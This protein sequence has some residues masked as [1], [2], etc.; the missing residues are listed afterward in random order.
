MKEAS[1]LKAAAQFGTGDI[2]QSALGDGLIH[3]TYNVLYV[4]SGRR[5]VLQCINQKTFPQPENIIRN[6]CMIYEHLNRPEGS[7]VQIPE[8]L[9]THDGRFFWIDEHGN[10]W[11]ATTFIP[12]TFTPSTLSSSAAAFK[13]A[14]CFGQFTRALADLDQDSLD[15]ILPGFHDLSK[16]YNAF[17]SA[18]SGANINRLLK[19]THLIAEIRQRKYYVEFYESVL[20][21]TN[22]YPRRLMH[23]D[24][25]VSNI[26]FDLNTGDPEMPVD[27][28]TTMPG[29]YFSDLGDMIRTMAC[30]ENEQSVSWENIGIDDEMYKSLLN[31][32]REGIGDILTDMEKRHIHFS[33]ILLTYM[34]CIRFL[35]D[36]LNNDIYY[37]TSYP[38]QNLNRALNQFILLEKLEE[39]L[40]EKYNWS[41]TFTGEPG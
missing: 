8:P 23:H 13:S 35:A 12:N 41:G 18:V 20:R 27:L 4:R 6:Y 31:G 39:Y 14:R 10:F 28:D 30:T 5:I 25:K 21:N 32:Y 2:I 1:I 15:I 9:K 19:S 36:F 17:E 24:C 7:P 26:L 33:G 3:R 11:R 40:A 16:R 22:D 38:E 29:Y 34:Q 37:H